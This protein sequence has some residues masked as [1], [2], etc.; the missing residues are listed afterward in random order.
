VWPHGAMA[1]SQEPVPLH[2]DAA[3]REA[4]AFLA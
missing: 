3:A 1:T 4:D 2:V